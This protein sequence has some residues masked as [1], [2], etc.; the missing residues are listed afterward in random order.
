MASDYGD[1]QW[2]Q[3]DKHN[4]PYMVFINL[5]PKFLKAYLEDKQVEIGELKKLKTCSVVQFVWCTRGVC[6]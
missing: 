5:F 3:S 2:K 6:S 1:E 4:C